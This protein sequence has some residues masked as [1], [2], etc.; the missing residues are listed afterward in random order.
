MLSVLFEVSVEDGVDLYA[1]TTIKKQPGVAGQ[2]TERPV[3]LALRKGACPTVDDC[4]GATAWLELF[5]NDTQELET[6][7]TL[8]T[9]YALP[10]TLG[11]CHGRTREGL[12]SRKAFPTPKPTPFGQG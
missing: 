12:A 9:T 1:G 8:D 4:A 3:H 10:L 5:V 2:S 6:P 7:I 11:A